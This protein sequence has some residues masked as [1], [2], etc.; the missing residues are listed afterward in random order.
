VLPLF[1]LVQISRHEFRAPEK[2]RAKR[3]PAKADPGKALFEVKTPN[4]L[5]ALGTPYPDGG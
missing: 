2:K 1:L 5:S 3:Q 4:R